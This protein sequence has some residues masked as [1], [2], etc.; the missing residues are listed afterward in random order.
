MCKD[1]PSVGVSRRFPSQCVLFLLTFGLFL[2]TPGPASA[3]LNFPPDGG[4]RNDRILVKPIAGV[5]LTPLHT[6][7]GIQVL[8][9]YPDIGGLQVLQLPL[10]VTV[11]V[12]IAIYQQSGLVQYAERD[13]FVLAL[14][15]PNDAY[16]A[17]GSLCGLNN[18]G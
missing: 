5:D 11:D 10:G 12:I 3:Q 1:A 17:D 13:L 8:R 9:T 18:I 14:T 6:L 4:F 16:F 15:T 7:I 2:I